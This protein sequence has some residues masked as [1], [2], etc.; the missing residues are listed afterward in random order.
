MAQSES[1]SLADAAATEAAGYTLAVEVLR[2]RL[3]GLVIGLE[4]ELGAGKTT[5][6]RGFLAGLG[7]HGRVPSPTYT[8]IEPYELDDYRVFHIDLYRIGT[9]RELEELDI[10]G[11]LTGR[12]IALIEWLGRGRGHL[13]EPDLLLS[14][15]LV[16]VGR[17]LD[18][19]ASSKRGASLLAAWQ[20]GWP[21]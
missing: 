18:C 2:A 10:A 17:A 13:P 19:L 3:P 6:A 5:F 7:H 15:R 4:G 21:V 9:A 12:A 11:Q 1:L 20:S 16:P 14:L 8:L